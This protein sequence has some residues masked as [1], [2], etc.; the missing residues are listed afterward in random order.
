MDIIGSGQIL[1][2]AAEFKRALNAYLEGLVA[3]PVRS[4]KDVI[5][6][7]NKFSKLVSI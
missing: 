7:Y 4:L 2:L 1:A 5:A 6:F 3:S